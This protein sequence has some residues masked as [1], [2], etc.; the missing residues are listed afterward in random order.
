MVGM[1][2]VCTFD[3]FL[4]IIRT[5]VLQ[6]EVHM[7]DEK[8]QKAANELRVWCELCSIRIAPNEE[9]KVDLGKSYHPACHS[10]AHPASRIAGR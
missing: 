2:G 8:R 9:R 7:K 10:K 5:I 4:P 1:S 3:R 6:T